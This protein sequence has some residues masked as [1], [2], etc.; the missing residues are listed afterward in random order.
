MPSSISGGE[1]QLGKHS[2]RECTHADE[3]HTAIHASHRQRLDRATSLLSHL[4]TRPVTWRV[5]GQNPREGWT[6]AVQAGG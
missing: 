6:P 3:T 5:V 4:T 1:G 2:A